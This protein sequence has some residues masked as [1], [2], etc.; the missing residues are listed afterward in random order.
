MSAPRGGVTSPRMTGSGMGTTLPCRVRVTWNCSAPGTAGGG[1]AGP[2][3]A[4][5][6]AQVGAPLPRKGPAPRGRM[7]WAQGTAPLHSSSTRQQNRPAETCRICRLN[8]SQPKHQIEVV[9]LRNVG[10]S[11]GPWPCKRVDGLKGVIH[12]LNP[13]LRLLLAST[14]RVHSLG[15]N[16]LAAMATVE[17]SKDAS[18]AQLGVAV[19]RPPSVKPR[20]HCATPMSTVPHHNG[21]GSI[22]EGHA[23]WLWRDVRN[24]SNLGGKRAW[25]PPDAGG[26]GTAP[27]PRGKSIAGLITPSHGRWDTK[28]GAQDRGI[29]DGVSQV[30]VPR[31]GMVGHVVTI[32]IGQDSHWW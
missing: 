29:H 7:N 23:V 27:L 1:K 26:Q 18:P 20:T 28:D 9:G 13:R 30:R 4:E 31:K 14:G 32:L 22:G 10:P 25:V 12:G 8:P 17:R 21:S 15:L 24:C 11:K 19:G 6:P 2:T 16:K 5:K 3:M